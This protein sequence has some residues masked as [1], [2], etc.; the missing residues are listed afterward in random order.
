L[1]AMAVMLM[2]C[3]PGVTVDT[4]NEHMLPTA[5]GVAGTTGVAFVGA[6]KFAVGVAA[7]L[8]GL[9]TVSPFLAAP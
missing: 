8:A 4:S 2:V 5:G 6:G 1:T 9:T 7:S 3:V